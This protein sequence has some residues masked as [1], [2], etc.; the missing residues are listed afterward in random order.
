MNGDRRRFVFEGADPYL[1]INGSRG[2]YMRG[3]VDLVFNIGEGNFPE[4]HAVI[5][6]DD[7]G[8]FDG[9]ANMKSLHTLTVNVDDKCPGG[10]FTLMKGKNAVSVFADVES[11]FVKGTGAERIK[12]VTTTEDGVEVV[13]AKIRKNSGLVLIL[14]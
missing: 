6:L 4:N 11:Q 9:D 7:A 10:T 3:A 14:R 1:R 12:F 5:E 8:K 2:F 13:R